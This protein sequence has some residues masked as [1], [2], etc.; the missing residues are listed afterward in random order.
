MN[1]ENQEHN[2]D[3]EAIF[4][5]LPYEAQVAA[6]CVVVAALKETAQ[7]G[8]SFRFF[9]YQMLGLKQDSYFPVWRSGG[10]DITNALDA[11]Q[12]MPHL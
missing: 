4:K 8:G 7:R 3:M 2:A 1:M 11:G 9:L 10:Q 6:T 5:A 12:F